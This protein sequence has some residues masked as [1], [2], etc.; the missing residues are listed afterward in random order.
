MDTSQR[1]HW[2]WQLDWVIGRAFGTTQETWT[3]KRTLEI[4]N[5]VREDETGGRVSLSVT[6]LDGDGD[7]EFVVHATFDEPQADGTRRVTRQR[8]GSGVRP[9]GSVAYWANPVDLPIQRL[10]GATGTITVL[11]DLDNTRMGR[12]R[13]IGN[14]FRGVA[15][16]HQGLL[17]RPA[18]Q[19]AEA[20]G[21]ADYEITAMA[22]SVSAS[23]DPATTVTAAV[24]SRIS[25]LPVSRTAL[26]AG[27]APD[28][29]RPRLYEP[30][31]PQAMAD[32]LRELFPDL[33]FPGADALPDNSVALMVG[34]SSLIA[35]YLAGLNHE[36]GREL[37]WRGFPSA[38]RATWFRRFFDAA[39]A[40][41]ATGDIAPI[42]DW[43]GAGDLAAR[44]PARPAT[45]ASSCWSGASCCAA[46]PTSSSRPP[47]RWTPPPGTAPTPPCSC[48][49]SPAGPVPTW[50]C[51]A[52][53]SPPRRSA[54]AAPTRAGSS[55]SPSRPPSPASA[56]P[57]PPTGPHP[58]RT[59]RRRCC[60]CRSAWRST[61]PT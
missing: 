36:F 55:S 47:A 49:S 43:G 40:N 50:P 22:A 30:S 35:A 42:S 60:G 59:L 2:V 21:R 45:A 24:T 39:G 26:A 23:V 16:R 57:P 38:G 27:P 56:A 52:S 10:A 53:P 32:P 11:G 15:I 61:P 5:R 25:P 44:P 51:S 34:N 12:V 9:D 29:L 48:P 58:A 19:A 13:D 14:S 3:D 17:I 1:V 37:L 54:A 8:I 41:P 28:P 46:T 18:T 4:G 20:P 33:V 6:D 31:F 7:P